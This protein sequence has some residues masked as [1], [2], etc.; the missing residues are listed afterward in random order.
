MSRALVVQRRSACPIAMGQIFP[1]R[2]SAGNRVAALTIGSVAY[3]RSPLAKVSTKR[4]RV[5]ILVAPASGKMLN[6]GQEAW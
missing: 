1:R 3:G 2:F 4:V 6:S 5:D